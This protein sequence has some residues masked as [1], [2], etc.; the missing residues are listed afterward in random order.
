M[1]ELEIAVQAARKAGKLIREKANVAK[2]VDLKSSAH[3]LVTE[4]DKKAE[5]LVREVILSHYPDHAILGEEGV[6]A[7]VEASKRALEEHRHHESLWVVDPIDGT[8][9]FVHGF[10]FFCVSIAFVR[11]QE[12]VVGVIYDPMRD[13][14]FTAEKGKGAF[15]NGERISVSEERTL[16][17]SLL[18]TGFPTDA[19]GVRRVNTEAILKLAPQVRNVR[20]AGSAALHLA[21]VAAGRLTGFWELELNAWDLAAGVLLVQEA[22]GEVSDTIG[23][24]YDLGVRHILASNGH[25]HHDVLR[26]LEEVKA[27]GFE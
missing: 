13:D 1:N 24:S 8:T 23:G 10:P 21:C 14:L 12:L 25:V 5:E 7:G 6:A 3:D 11:K 17:E 22:G 27:T 18:A 26:V 15:L 19:R 20:T 2:R 4:V 16:S 9:N